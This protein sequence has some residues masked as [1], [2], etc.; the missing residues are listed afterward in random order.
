MSPLH[1]PLGGRGNRIQFTK[2]LCEKGA[3]KEWPVLPVAEEG[4][5]DPALSLSPGWSPSAPHLD[6]YHPQVGVVL[7]DQLGAQRPTG[8]AEH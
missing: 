8:R 2:W 6:S 4:P 5:K 3:K 1:T 7:F